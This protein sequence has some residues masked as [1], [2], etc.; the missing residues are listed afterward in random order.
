MKAEHC[1]DCI[2]ASIRHKLLYSCLLFCILT[3]RVK[4]NRHFENVTTYT[5]NF[6]S[7]EYTCSFGVFPRFSPIKYVNKKQLPILYNAPKIFL[8]KMNDFF[9]ILFELQ[10]LR[11]C[12]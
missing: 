1:L 8:M 7:M 2:T 6:Q 9:N 3:L 10:L 5:F 4:I 11:Y 12:Q